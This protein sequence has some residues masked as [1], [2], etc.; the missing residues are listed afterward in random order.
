MAVIFI[1]SAQP[2]AKLPKFDLFD[3]VIK[4][5][6]HFVGYG[7][8]ALSYL[9]GFGERKNRYLLA[10]LLA[11]LYAVTD[12]LH[13]SFVPG[14]RASIWDILIFDNLGAAAALVIYCRFSTLCTLRP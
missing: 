12:E 3:I 13:Q 1:L 14:R 4:K 2:S 7:L 9:Y 5:G 8:L 10:W 6:G 11:L